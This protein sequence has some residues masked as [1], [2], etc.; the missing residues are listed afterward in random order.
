MEKIGIITFHRADNYG[1][2]L[3]AYA[4]QVY[5]EKMGCSVQIV[6]YRFPEMEQSYKLFRKKSEM[7]IVQ[8]LKV[9]AHDLF[10]IKRRFAFE[11]FRYDN[12]KLSTVYNSSS[13][14]NSNEE[15]SIFITGSDQVWNDTCS[16]K[17]PVYCLTFADESKKLLSFAASFGYADIEKDREI[18]YANALAKMTDISIREKS[19]I[20]LVEK[21]IGKTPEQ[22]PDPTLMLDIDSWN[23]VATFPSEK[24][25]ILVYLLNAR[26]EVLY[27]AKE[28]SEKTNL[29]IVNITDDN[30]NIIGAKCVHNA[31]PAEFLGYFNNAKYVITNSFHGLMF[32]IIY[33]KSMY[34]DIPK[35]SRTTYERLTNILDELGIEDRYI[36]NLPGNFTP[37]ELDYR[38]I[39]EKI[40]ALQNKTN[41]FFDRNLTIDCR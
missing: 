20:R 19:G 37:Q 39:E 32:S 40:S 31:G 3:Q 12:L 13:I 11:K 24:G 5:L 6:D 14:S 38:E 23:K 35:G 41:V 15:F 22:I 28:L 9:I 1:A 33:R 26:E 17:D 25:Y 4:S 8:Y 29:K 30:R 16:L 34:V 18:F 10:R 2:V 7:S 27:F 36:D 21:L